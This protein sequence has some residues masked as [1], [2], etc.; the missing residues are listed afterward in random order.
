MNLSP[1]TNTIGYLIAIVVSGFIG[2]WHCAFMCGP[3]ACFISEKK[4]LWPYQL[5]RLLGY[6]VLGFF[7]GFISSLFF[8][9]EYAYIRYASMIIMLILI[10][11]GFLK[12]FKV[13][14]I[15]ISSS[16]RLYFKFKD[17]AFMLGVL[18]F[19]LPCGW[20]YTFVLAAAATG[21]KMVGVL[22]MV[23]FWVST[24]P[25]L[26]IGQVFLTKV[27]GKVNDRQ[28]LISRLVLL[29]SAIYSLS[30]FYFLH[31]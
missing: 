4:S 6:S 14:T 31:S 29:I 5:G 7:S 2:S 27:I 23:L 11:Y 25:S 12:T 22:V 8:K 1:E 18:T 24:L 21:S 30:L 3:V 16:Q 17:S 20:L 28:K 15:Q 10:V 19:L 13:T 26:T 9:S